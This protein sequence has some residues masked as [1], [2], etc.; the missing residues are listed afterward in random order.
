MNMLSSFMVKVCVAIVALAAAVAMAGN[1]SICNVC[2]NPRFVNPKGTT[3]LQVI[4]PG[5]DKPLITYKACPNPKVRLVKG[6]IQVSCNG[7]KAWPL[8]TSPPPGK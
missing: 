8:D 1:L 5:A 3:E 6:I 7:V 4:C 2:E